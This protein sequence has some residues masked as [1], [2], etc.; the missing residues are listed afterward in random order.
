MVSRRMWF[1]ELVCRW[2]CAGCRLN[3]HND[4]AV[5]VAFAFPWRW[6]PQ[7][8]MQT[9]RVKEKSV[10]DE[11]AEDIELG[12]VAPKGYPRIHDSG[13]SAAGQ[14]RRLEPNGQ[15]ADEAPNSEIPSWQ[16]PRLVVE[17]SRRPG[18][19]V[20]KGTSLIL[21]EAGENLLSGIL[22]SLPVLLQVKSCW[23]LGYSMAV[24]GVSLRTLY[25]QIGEVGP[26][27]LI[28]EDSSY[29]IFGAFLS[30]GL[31]PVNQCY[32]TNE[33]FVFRY[34]RAAGAWRT[35][36]F[37][38]A[39]PGS[40]SSVQDPVAGMSGDGSC[41]DG[42]DAIQPD[43]RPT[44]FEALRKCQSWVLSAA[45][46]TQ[47]HAVFCDHTGIV[48]GIDGPGLFIDQDLLRGVSFAS[49]C[50]GS[51]CLSATGP[52]FVVRNLEVWHW[53]E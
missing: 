10:E 11:G 27:L 28:V 44:Q 15:D 2:R 49:K 21:P 46:G 43:G 30:E 50:F 33:C 40:D 31:K 22:A 6:C 48:I 45:N 42:D 16:M 26:C 7:R 47:T 23:H 17:C 51:P 18:A 12:V 8:C 9:K 53:T 52:E 5:L 34:P 38:Q 35:E 13:N 41:A 20:H 24:D 25:R 4:A 36:V 3:L 37:G 19:R 14:P 32:G 1:Q 29:C 39:Q